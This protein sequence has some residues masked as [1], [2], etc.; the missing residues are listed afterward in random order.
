MRLFLT[1][2]L[3]LL[4]TLVSAVE[5]D[6]NTRTLSLGPATQ[7]FEDPTG[8]ATIKQVSSP[9]GQ[10]RFSALEGNA[11]NAGFSESVFWLKVT[12]T[13]R[14]VN[15]VAF[16]DWL[17]ELAYPPMDHVD[18]YLA[19]ETAEPSLTWQTGDML[20]FD[21]RQV[22]QNNYLFELNLAPN[23]SKT[24]YV[25]VSS[26]GSVQAPLNLWASHA[27]IEAQ[28]ARLYILG[29]IYGVLAV[30]LVYNLF[31]YLS[32]RDRSY[33]YYILYICCF[34]LYQVSINGAG[35][36]FLWP[37]SPWWANTSTT[38]LIGAAILFASQ[39]ARK[40]LQTPRLGRWLDVPLQLMTACAAVIMLLSLTQDYGIALRLVTGLVL[41]FTPV[42]LL[43]GIVAWLR[44][45]R[46]ARYFIF[47]WSAF[48]LGGVINTTMLLGLLPN[49]FW[50]MYAS[51]IGSVVEV[52]LLSLALADRINTLRERQA[53]ILA[54]SGRDL[55]ALN[56]QLAVSNRLKDEFLAMLTHE[57]RTPMNG[58]IGSLELMQMNGAEDD[59]ELYRQTAADSAQ[60]MMG[61]VNGILT[62]TELQ[63][64][65]IEVHSEAFSLRHLLFQL[66]STF[67]PPARSK[68]LALSVELDEALPDSLQGDALKLRQCLECLVDNAIKFTRQGSIRVCVKG[69]TD[70]QQVRLL[71]D[72]IDTGIGF[73]R[74][75]EDTLYANFYQVDGSMTREYGGLGIGLAICRQ[76]I[77]L[78]GGRLSH[79]SEPGNGSQ[80]RLSLDI[81]R[82]KPPQQDL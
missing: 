8:A 57:L 14:P 29:M 75:D 43:I 48:L 15:P 78:Q 81:A 67:E 24:A 55:E 65:R 76:L 39:F 45:R 59:I 23:Q 17:L 60:N 22:K 4:P 18:L 2:L 30:M 80:F 52:A 21:S 40:F 28:P 73:V 1:L 79:Q 77:E 20:P 16:A 33:L 41:L 25:R 10:S 34:G 71:I 66:R 46:V 56:Q 74:L 64:G 70:D 3:I 19:S 32:V 27:Y 9:E 58:V 31:I 35:I 62:L 38:F 44:G 47:A 50:T 61:I 51:Q 49:N 26:H 42:I 69:H 5:F 6:E 13:Y 36:E 7:V 37:N 72:V 53:H 68:A 54:Q 12:L 11:L 82:A 63:A